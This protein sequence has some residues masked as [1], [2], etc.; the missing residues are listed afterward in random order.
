MTQTIRLIT[1][2]AVFFNPL[3]LLSQSFTIGTFDGQNTSTSYPTAYGDRFE[4]TRSQFLYRAAELTAAGATAGNIIRLGFFVEDVTDVGVHENYTIKL[5]LTTINS[6]TPGAW[7]NDGLTTVYGPV[8]Y[9][10]VVG[11]NEHIVADPFYWNG[12]ANLIVEICHTAIPANGGNTSSANAVVQLTENLAFN[13]SRT[14]A[15]NNDELIC[16][17]AQSQ[18][19]GIPKSRPVLSLSFC[20]P[21]TELTLNSI[22]S[23][24]A[25][26]GW[27]PHSGGAPAGYQ[28]SFGLEGYQPGVAGVEIAKGVTTDT[29]VVLTGLSGLTIYSVWVRSDCGDGYSQWTGPLDFQTDP[30]C[31]DPFNDT[32]G[33]IFPYSPGENY[34]KVFCPDE[35]DNAL[36]M[37]FFL[38][39]PFSSGTGDTL[40]IY[41]GD[42]TGAPLLATLSGVYGNAPAQPTPGPFTSTTASGC[43]TVHFTSDTVS[44]SAEQGWVSLLTCAP[45][46]ANECYEVLQLDTANVTPE[47]ADLS[48]I[49]MFGAAGYQWELVELPDLGA[50]SIVQQEAAYVG[51]LVNFNNLQSGTAYRFSIRTN[52]INDEMS[53]WVTILFNTPVK[54][55]GPIVQCDMTNLVLAQ[56]TGIW[57]INECN[58]SNPGKERVF[59]FVAPNT[60]SYNFEVLSAAGGYVSYFFKAASSG[61]NDADWHCIDDFNNPGSTTLP[62]VPGG[63]LTA[64]QLYYILCDP[65]STGVV[66]HTFKISECGPPPN[67][68]PLNAIPI[69]V[70]TPCEDNV[71]SNIGSGIDPGE[72]DPD[73]DDTDGL[74]GRWQDAADET[75]WFTFVA[76]A[77]GTVTIFTNPQSA[78]LPNDDTQVALYSVGDPADYGT[79]KLLV[80]DEDN[81]TAYLGFNSVVSYTGLSAGQTYYIQ[82]DGWGINSGA[83]CIAVIETIE[84]VTSASCDVDY[85]LT[86]VNGDSWFGIYATPDDLDIGPLVAAINPNDFDLGTVNCRIQTY[87]D[88]PLSANNIPYLPVYYYFTSSLAPAGEIKLRLF[89][90]NPDLEELKVAANE[91]DKGI[92]DLVISRFNG[93]IADCEQINNESP[94]TILGVNSATQMVGT[95][96]LEFFTNILG[97]FGAHFGLVPLPLKLNYFTGVVQEQANLLKW[98]TLQ[99]KNVEW[100]LVE[101]SLNG[102]AWTEIGRVAGQANSDLPKTYSLEDPQPPAKAYYRLRSLDFDGTASVSQAVLL[103]RP[104]GR[105]GITGIYPSPTTDKL[106]V[107]F[108][109]LQ[110][111]DID[112]RLTDFTGRT[113]M[114]TQVAAGKGSNSAELSLVDLPAGVYAV[115]ITADGVV[116][117]PARVVKQ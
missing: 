117:A 94:S 111:A 74:V 101:R 89:F 28:W 40:K 2:I 3:L 116:S 108:D 5:S 60:K 8:D 31:G 37:S 49:D 43:L 26:V 9:T 54:C 91:P 113:V 109:V 71:Y 70:N 58:V 85:T 20:Y 92:A 7:E 88:I 78:F 73:V 106:N 51:S 44:G 18:E 16:T 68:S 104:G 114:E 12:T 80:S 47:S 11:L 105:L 65:Q 97:E 57:N 93:S 67:D 81:G 48:W 42:N 100:H 90:T 87:A 38:P 112:I 25:N 17:T 82:V 84:P 69:T 77:T 98:E 103:N 21:P 22:A 41:N 53:D 115:T 13:G 10:P 36:S 63:T 50:A 66:N 52:C 107:Q 55:N 15:V 110:E 24:S 75:V 39:N 56:K 6:L 64:G 35:P 45:L 4:S 32:G 102:V 79:Y 76:P 46:P 86:D 23:I 30:S 83:F 72:P 29:S 95:F 1:A 33:F 59:Q 99:E 61:C 19:N 14:R 62:A 96:Y 34:V 27:S